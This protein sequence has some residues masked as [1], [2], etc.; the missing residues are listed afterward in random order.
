M[1]VQQILQTFTN[2]RTQYQL[3]KALPEGVTISQIQ[4]IVQQYVKHI[5]TSFN[6]QTVRAVVL[7]GALHEQVWG[8]VVD[9]IPGDSGKKRPTSAKN[10]AYGT[11]VFFDDEDAISRATEKYS[12]YFDNV[13][14][15]TSN[16]AVQIAT[17]ATIGELGLGGHL[18]HYNALVEKALAGKVPQSWKVQAQLVFGTPVGTP[19][20]KQFDENDVKVLDL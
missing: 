7:I 9:A 16:G 3:S 2:R 11:I 17:W 20:D 10:E 8:S 13:Y 1:S 5:P 18:Q 4:E 12:A 14:N 19:Y 15:S 6:S